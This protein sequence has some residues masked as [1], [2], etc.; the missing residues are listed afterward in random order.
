[1]IALPFVVTMR[2]SRARQKIVHA[3]SAVPVFVIGRSREQ[4]KFAVFLKPAI[5]TLIAHT[6]NKLDGTREVQTM[7]NAMLI[8][9]L[10]ILL[11][12]LRAIEG[13][14]RVSPKSRN[15]AAWMSIVIKP[16]LRLARIKG[17]NFRDGLYR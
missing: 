4:Q 3:V 2:L 17:G 14:I 16:A 9:S 8:G 6:K 12:W 13:K 10:V 1:V 5:G 15:P 11:A 7:I